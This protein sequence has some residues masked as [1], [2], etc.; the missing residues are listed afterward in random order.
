MCLFII[1]QFSCANKFDNS[2]LKIFKYNE[3]N[4]LST[5]D[6]AFAK[7]KATIWVTS[8]IFNSLVKM[9]EELEVIPSISSSWKIS[10]DGLV[11]TFFLRKDVY[12]HD[13]K[14]FENGKGR[15][16]V[17]SD[18]VYSFDRLLNPKLASPGVDFK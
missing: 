12:F 13:H 14:S 16:V 4:G 10:E 11:Y 5:L 18:F 7:D 6:P 15:R 9:N 8:Q 1:F 17:A 2:N 3:S